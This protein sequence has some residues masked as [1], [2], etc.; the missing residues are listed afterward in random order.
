MKSYDR[1]TKNEE[2]LNQ[3]L[4][5]IKNLDYSLDEF[6]NNKE[7]IKKL[8]KYYGSREWFL[9]KEKVEEGTLSNIKAG[10]LSEDSI[11]N[12]FEDI[13]DIINKMNFIIKEYEK[14]EK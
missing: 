3:V 8:D 7:N 4:L 6:Q 10:V 14:S 11:W 13:K 5:S 9:D 12:M 2:R 1:I